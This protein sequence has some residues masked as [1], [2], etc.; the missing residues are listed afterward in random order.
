MQKKKSGG[1][2]NNFAHVVKRHVSARL[3]ESVFA[4]LCG[5]ITAQWCG[6]VT[7][8]TASA[9]HYSLQYNVNEFES[10][11]QSYFIPHNTQTR[12]F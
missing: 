9:R 4:T 7:S 8:I 10:S 3:H 5:N 1:A 6:G 12:P 11:M 2:D